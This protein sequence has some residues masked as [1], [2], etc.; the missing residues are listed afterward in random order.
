MDRRSLQ[1]VW[2]PFGEVV[3][4]LLPADRAEIERAGAW[5]A[6]LNAGVGDPWMFDYV[7]MLRNAERSDRRR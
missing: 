4:G 2:N 6:Y 3:D 7:T 1:D 5:A